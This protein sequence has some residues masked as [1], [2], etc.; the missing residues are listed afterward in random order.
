M[1]CECIRAT[2]S[3]ERRVRTFHRGLCEVRARHVCRCTKTREVVENE[4]R[5]R[6]ELGGMCPRMNGRESSAAGLQR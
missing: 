4:G 5:G 3:V 2:L 6:V 1:L